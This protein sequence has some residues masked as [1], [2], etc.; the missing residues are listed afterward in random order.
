[1]GQG[2]RR[3][4]R[5]VQTL[6]I[7]ALFAMIILF[8]TCDGRKILASF[9][10][11]EVFAVAFPADLP[12]VELVNIFRKHGIDTIVNESNVLVP[13][14]DF[15]RLQYLSLS[16]FIRRVQ[17]DDPRSTPLSSLLVSSFT[18]TT[19]TATTTDGPWRVWYVPIASSNVYKGTQKA[20]T[21]FGS[22]WA[23]DAQ[24]PSPVLHFLWVV[25][26]AW[27]LWLLIA[28]QVK[29]RLYHGVLIIA[30]LPVA[31]FQ[32]LPAA[33]L[34]VVGQG[35]SAILGMDAVS[36]G[37]RQGLTKIHVGRLFSNLLP[38]LLSMT[39][40]VFIDVNLLIPAVISIG[41]TILFIVHK[42]SV[43][44][45]LTKKRMHRYPPFRLIIEDTIRVK[46]A[47]LGSWVLIPLAMLA[48]ILLIV[49]YH[50][51][52]NMAY[53]LTFN[54]DADQGFFNPD[55]PDMIRSHTM[56]QEALTFGRL[57]DA[58]W[59]SDSY[60][61]PYHYQVLENRIVRGEMDPGAAADGFQNSKELD[62]T[63]KLVLEHTRGGIPMVVSGGDIPG[64]RAIQLDSQGVVFYIMAMAPFCVLGLH[65]VSQSK[66]RTGTSYTNRQVA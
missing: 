41:M 24:L 25:W 1:M 60:S 61:R 62:K 40:L 53:R 51:D 15:V 63:M 66:R 36:N 65:R 26:L 56:F 35:L 47:R 57:G 42:D 8:S 20:F 6:A 22:D 55:Y 5:W 17:A 2:T 12:Q 50:P 10:S 49:P 11:T 14:T 7:P 52:E 27:T 9:T 13:M 48:I 39:L 46:A 30:W 16:E 38:F 18:A 3:Y 37:H 33:A 59:M 4:P 45:F 31:F 44:G 54:T 43:M 21:E 19:T 58:D 64:I 34:M 29:D 28:K 23:W 32:S